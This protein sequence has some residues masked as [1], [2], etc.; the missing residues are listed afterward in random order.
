MT[1][2]PARLVWAEIH[3]EISRDDV[4]A[5]IAALA[6]FA[7][8]RRR[9]LELTAGSTPIGDAV[10]ALSEGP[11]RPIDGRTGRKERRSGDAEIFMSYPEGAFSEDAIDSL[12]EEITNGAPSIEKLPDTPYVQSNIWIFAILS[13]ERMVFISFGRLSLT[14]WNTKAA[15]E[16]LR[17]C[18]LGVYGQ[19]DRCL[20][21][22]KQGADHVIGGRLVDGGRSGKQPV[23]L[24]GRVGKEGIATAS[25]RVEVVREGGARNVLMGRQGWVGARLIEI[26]APGPGM[27]R[28]H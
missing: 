17:T 19:V 8:V 14:R 3:T 10:N 28:T 4:A 9:V 26:V 27:Y 16:A 22:W 13:R 21:H 12:A 1:P 11:F 5:T 7:E 24:A 20:W 25:C 6:E 2:E 23:V 18:R 15:N